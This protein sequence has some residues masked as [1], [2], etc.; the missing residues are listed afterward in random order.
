MIDYISIEII[1]TAPEI[2]T[3]NSLLNF[4]TGVNTGSGEIEQKRH[5][6]I[7]QVAMYKNLKIEI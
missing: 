3:S 5:G 7:N 1:N 6:Y 4:I 2:L